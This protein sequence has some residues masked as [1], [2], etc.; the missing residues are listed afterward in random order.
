M[1][2]TKKQIYQNKLNLN[3]DWQASAACSSKTKE[4]DF[5]DTVESHLKVLSKKYCKD[6]PVRTRCLYVALVNEDPYGLWGGLTPKQRKLYLKQIYSFAQEHN[7][8][9]TDWNN[10]LDEVFKLFSTYQDYSDIY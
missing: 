9:I 2:Q 3:S 1:N 10:K 8:P 6:C 4:E 7:I 5:Y